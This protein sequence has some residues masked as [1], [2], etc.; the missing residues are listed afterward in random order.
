M[1]TAIFSG[2]V[3]YFDDSLEMKSVHLLTSNRFIIREREKDNCKDQPAHCNPID[4][5]ALYIPHVESSTVHGLT[6]KYE[7]RQS[8]NEIR[9]V[10]DRDGRSQEGV[11]SS[12]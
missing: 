4:D 5:H 11:E 12:G 6:P 10:I 2:L 1:L 9:Q 3:S 8:G 7:V